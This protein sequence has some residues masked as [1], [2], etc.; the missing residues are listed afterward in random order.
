MVT[1]W[2]QPSC[3][4][5]DRQHRPAPAHAERQP[6]QNLGSETVRRATQSRFVPPTLRP[7]AVVHRLQTF[8]RFW[9]S[10]PTSGVLAEPVIRPVISQSHPPVE[11]GDDNSED[12]LMT[13][14][15]KLLILLF[16]L[17]YSLSVYTEVD[18]SVFVKLVFH[19][20]SELSSK[21]GLT[22]LRRRPRGILDVPG[23][24]CLRSSEP[25]FASFGQDV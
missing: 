18:D 11:I 2:R 17:T 20:S 7:T 3:H 23:R 6:N 4:G 12:K 1:F 21:Q 8:C 9:N 10:V 25:R 19:L 15:T 16:L 5:I 22:L 14:L 13:T 24:S